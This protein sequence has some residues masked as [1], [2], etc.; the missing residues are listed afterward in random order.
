MYI[1]GLVL[2]AI[3]KLEV[4]VPLVLDDDVLFA[5]TIDEVIGKDINGKLMYHL[6]CIM[7]FYLLT[8]YMKL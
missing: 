3:E 5:H 2:M 7:M 6:S 1:K 8:L 4:D